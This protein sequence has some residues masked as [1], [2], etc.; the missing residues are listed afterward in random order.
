MLLYAPLNLQEVFVPSGLPLG[1]YM[2]VDSNHK[3]ELGILA[4]SLLGE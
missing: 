4:T 1:N 2:M 3:I